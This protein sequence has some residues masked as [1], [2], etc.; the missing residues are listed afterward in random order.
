MAD[1]LQVVHQHALLGD[2]LL[3][4]VQVLQYAAGTGAEMGHWGHPL[5]RG[6]QHLQRARLVEMAAA[7]C[8]FG[9]HHLTGQGAADEGN[10]AALAFTAGDTATI[11]AEVEDLGLERGTVGAGAGSGHVATGC[12]QNGAYC[13]RS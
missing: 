7:G 6:L 10:L 3:G 5:R 11:M 13:R 2:D 4:L 9:H 12:G 1:P 8:L